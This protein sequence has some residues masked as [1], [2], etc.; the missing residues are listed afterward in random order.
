MTKQIRSILVAFAAFLLVLCAADFASAQ[1]VHEVRPAG[2]DEVRIGVGAN[3]SM[4]DVL[5]LARRISGN[6]ALTA[7]DVITNM[8]HARRYVCRSGGRMT[9]FGRDADRCTEGETRSDGLIRGVAYR[10][11]R[12]HGVVLARRAPPDGRLR[13]TQRVDSSGRIAELERRLELTSGRLRLAEQVVTDA[14]NA[15]IRAESEVT[16]LRDALASAERERDEAR[17]ALAARP[18]VAHTGA[19]VVRDEVPPFT[20]ASRLHGVPVW[21]WLVILALALFGGA[22]LIFGFLVLPF[23][24]RPL[25]ERLEESEERRRAHVEGLQMQIDAIDTDL[26]R[27]VARAAWLARRRAALGTLVVHYRGVMAKSQDALSGALPKLEELKGYYDRKARIAE[28]HAKLMKLRDEEDP[29]LHLETLIRQTETD[30]ELAVERDDARAVVEYDQALAIYRENLE[31]LGDASELRARIAG[32]TTLLARDVQLQ[33]GV[34]FDTCSV[35]ERL[36]QWE[37]RRREELRRAVTER[38]RYESLVSALEER[39]LVRVA[40]ITSK[41]RALESDF[42]SKEG[43]LAGRHWVYA[44]EKHEAHEA[45]RAKERELEELRESLDEHRRLVDA[46]AGDPS[47]HAQAILQRDAFIADQAMKLREAGID[48]ATLPATPSNGSWPEEELTEELPLPGSASAYG[49]RAPRKRVPTLVVGAS[50]E[51]VRVARDSQ[52]PAPPKSPTYALNHAVSKLLDEFEVLPIDA[53]VLHTDDSAAAEWTRLLGLCSIST[54][55]MGEVPFRKFLAVVERRA[56]DWL[57]ERRRRRT[58][59]PPAPSAA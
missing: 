26:K 4:E 35:D 9:Y 23:E 7:D 24:K 43:E 32:L 21:G 46:F 29:F 50:E 17:A 53:R 51:A 56:P 49:V 47:A 59:P 11:P 13:I 54:P 33:C 38:A 39:E 31:S 12:E 58:D 42:A 28:N 45:L 6:E 41:R 57:A 55:T 14:G 5:R 10:V 52:L 44:L 36:A 1:R 48:P 20:F 25:I 34:A 30:R 2:A 37:E 19:R 22:F 27:E 15:Q 8:T 40:E 16:R 3:A 18:A